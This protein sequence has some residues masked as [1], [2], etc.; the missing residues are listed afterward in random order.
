MVDQHTG[1]CALQQGQQRKQLVVL[2]LDL[3]IQVQFGQ[4][5]H[6]AVDLHEAFGTQQRGVERHTDDT[7]CLVLRER[8]D[9]DVVRHHDHAFM[10]AFAARQRVQ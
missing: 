4:A 6:Q 2:H 10:A 5:P 3:G 8:L 7:L 9:V 1:P